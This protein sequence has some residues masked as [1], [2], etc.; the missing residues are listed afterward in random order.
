MLL[1]IFLARVLTLLIYRRVR[2]RKY[3]VL[4]SVCV[5]LLFVFTWS[6]LVVKDMALVVRNDLQMTLP[7]AVIVRSF[8]SVVDLIA[9]SS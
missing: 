8:R 1:G 4:I 5:S 2:C 6:Y 9:L 7:F 3:K